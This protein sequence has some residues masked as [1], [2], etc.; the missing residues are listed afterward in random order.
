MPDDSVARTIASDA[1]E[2]GAE[3][4]LPL[5]FPKQAS[6]QNDSGNCRSRQ[7]VV[8]RVPAK[9]VFPTIPTPHAAREAAGAASSR[10]KETG[11]WLRV[12]QPRVFAR[13]VLKS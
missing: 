13:K 6:A 3:G 4:R 9:P 7:F 8:F 5:L 12:F 2:A 10:T 11:Y 1:V